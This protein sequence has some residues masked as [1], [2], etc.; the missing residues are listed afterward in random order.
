MWILS[1]ML[2]LFNLFW[3]SAQ[4]AL[5]CSS[6]VTR[7]GGGGEG[8]GEGD[9]YC[10][11]N[12][13]LS[14][15][16]LFW[17]SAQVALSCSSTVTWSSNSLTWNWKKENHKIVNNYDWHCKFNQKRLMKLESSKKRYCFSVEFKLE[18]FG[19]KT[20]YYRAYIIFIFTPN[21]A[22]YKISRIKNPLH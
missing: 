22:H 20:K 1:I 9:T 12:N 21:R 11:C 3:L 16:N 4:V 8:R 2:S 17:L 13:M 18:F 5:S 19:M 15:F 6:N 14:L 10:W 7:G